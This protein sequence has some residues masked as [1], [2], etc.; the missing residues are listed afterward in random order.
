MGIMFANTFGTHRNVACGLVCVTHAP[1]GCLSALLS[2]MSITPVPLIAV[3]VQASIVHAVADVQLTQVYVNKE[4]QP[5]EAIYYFPV[6]SNGGITRFHAE[7]EGRTIK[8]VVKPQAEAVAQ[9][10]KA[11]QEQKSAFLLESD[12][13]DIFKEIGRAHV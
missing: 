3:D 8:G 9:Y 2:R 6:D 13:L 1:E 5:I 10:Q 12:K 4:S 7:L 11:V